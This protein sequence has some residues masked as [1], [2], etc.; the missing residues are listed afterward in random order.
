[1][2][3]KA[4]TLPHD[5]VVDCCTKVVNTFAPIYIKL[6]AIAQVDEESH[7]LTRTSAVASRPALVLLRP[8]VA[9]EPLEKGWMTKLGGIKKNWKRRYFVAKEEADNFVI[10]YFETE[11][12][13]GNGTKPKGTIFPC[14]YSVKALNSAA[15]IKV[16]GEHCLSLTPLDRK[17]TW[18]LRCESDEQ[19][20]RWKLVLRYAALKCQAPL[21][22]DKVAAIAFKEAYGRT[23]RQ[24]DMQ[25]F[26]AI[27]R[28]E[29]QQLAVLCVQACE[30]TVLHE[31]YSSTYAAI[32][33]ASSSAVTGTAVVYGG[34]SGTSSSTGTGGTADV[35]RIRAQLD[36]EVD[37]IAREVVAVA[38]PAILARA[39]LRKDFLQ[40]HVSTSLAALLTER[41][42]MLS[43][44]RLRLNT[45]PLLN[46]V[47]DAGVRSSL[48]TV[49]GALLKPQYKASEFCYSQ[50]WISLYH[51]AALEQN[52][53]TTHIC[54]RIKLQ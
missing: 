3:V 40:K 11:K 29:E 46:S 2:G 42:A 12:D 15:E 16:Y 28:P 53:Y 18:Y 31:A 41:E 39:D 30:E 10:Q 8:P 49:L 34:N 21:S 17:R 24:L 6:L 20:R 25:G 27:D 1:M 14:G 26:Y 43:V 32:A 52:A 51:G 9:T 38:W 19:L 36:G 7:R 45:A 48:M 13:A 47:F 50:H 44:M 5:S 22:T 37:R 23:R 4:S 35:E 33:A 54:R